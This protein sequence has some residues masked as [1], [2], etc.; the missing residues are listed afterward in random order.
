MVPTPSLETLAGGARQSGMALIVSL[1]FLLLLTMIGISSMQNANLQEKMAGSVSL[2]NQSFQSTE[3]VLRLGES[4][5]QDSTFA[6]TACTY[7]LPP[8]ESG[9]VKAAG[10]YS[11][12]GSSS[13]LEWL[14]KGSG[15]YLIQN[16]G[17]TAR[18]VATPPTCSS[19]SSFNLYRVTAVSS[20][21]SSTTVL[22]SIYAKCSS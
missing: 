1:V 2:R 17:V 3:A 15:F 21:G 9:K 10:R 11:G 16:L 14:A 20:Q 19:A 5:I 7:C 8:P 6:L 4:S 12:A 22:E 13:G 18:P